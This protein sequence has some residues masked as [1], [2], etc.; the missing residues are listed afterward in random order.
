MT[1][2]TGEFIDSMISQVSAVCNRGAES[3]VTASPLAGKIAELVP[4]PSGHGMGVGLDAEPRRV[5]SMPARSAASDCAEHVTHTA[6]AQQ[7]SARGSG[8]SGVAT[9]PSPAAP[10]KLK[11]AQAMDSVIESLGLPVVV[12]EIC[13]FEGPL[14][15]CSNPR[16]RLKLCAECM[17]DHGYEEAFA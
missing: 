1:Q 16:C 2:Y 6:D 17:H 8:G 11:L 10:V 7:D 3:A 15:E 4:V 5:G 9:Q 12:C 13:E 14:T